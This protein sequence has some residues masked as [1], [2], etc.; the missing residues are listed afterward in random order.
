MAASRGEEAIHGSLAPVRSSAGPASLAL[1]CAVAG[2]LH[3]LHYAA[4]SGRLEA[5]VISAAAPSPA[6][7]SLPAFITESCRRRPSRASPATANHLP[8][9]L[10]PPCPDGVHRG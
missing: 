7:A 1:V 6:V 4:S 9:P 3:P 8:A 2:H 5:A 10:Q